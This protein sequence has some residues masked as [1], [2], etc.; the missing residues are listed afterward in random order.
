MECDEGA[1]AGPEAAAQAALRVI[2]VALEELRSRLEAVHAHLAASD[3]AAMLV[4]EGG[5][6]VSAELRATIEC[7]LADSL[8]PA[9][10]DLAAAASH[11]P[12]G[13]AS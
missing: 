11:R 2:V 8:D 4:G 9:I 12:Q 3:G 13:R 1:F 6:S 7:V 10:R 5:L